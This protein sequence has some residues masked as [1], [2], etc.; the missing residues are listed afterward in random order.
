MKALTFSAIGRTKHRLTLPQKHVDAIIREL[1]I[2]SLDNYIITCEIK[3]IKSPQ[4]I[5]FLD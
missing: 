1:G 4:G 3:S 5:E 2:P